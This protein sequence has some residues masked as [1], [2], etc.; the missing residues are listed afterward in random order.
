F[1]WEE[2]HQLAEELEHV[3]SKQLTD[4]LDEY[5]GFPQFDPHGDPI[6][7]SKGKIR[8][9]EKLPLDQLA[10]NEP[11]EVC[12]VAQSEEILELLEHRNIT[13]GTRIEI[14][15]RFG[16]DQSLEVKVRNNIF[17]ISEQLARSI[18]VKRK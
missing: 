4:R 9:M 16:F 2:V 17:T 6:P 12:Q 11:A 15:K 8:A 14:K 3:S 5:L 10:V 7:D 1:G 18:F 13:I